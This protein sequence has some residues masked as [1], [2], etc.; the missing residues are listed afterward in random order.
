MGNLL[1]ETPDSIQNN[2]QYDQGGIYYWKLWSPNKL[3]FDM[4][5]GGNL[6]LETPDSRQTNFQYDQRLTYYW[7]LLTPDK[8][9]LIFNMIKYDTGNKK[10]LWNISSYFKFFQELSQLWLSTGKDSLSQ[11]SQIDFQRSKSV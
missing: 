4:I 8:L 7:K 2:F 1:L 5:T 6:L 9:K 3:I 11:E 10:K